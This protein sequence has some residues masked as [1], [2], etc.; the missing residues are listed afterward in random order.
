MNYRTKKV[1]QATKIHW[2]KLELASPYTNLGYLELETCNLHLSLSQTC[3]NLELDY[4]QIHVYNVLE[5]KVKLKKETSNENSI[6]YIKRM[7]MMHFK[8]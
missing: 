4:F 3:D 8:K 6:K 7:I 1:I 2:L 5:H